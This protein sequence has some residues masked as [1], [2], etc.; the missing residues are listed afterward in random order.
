LA[1]D[2]NRPTKKQY[3]TF[4]FPCGVNYSHWKN[5]LQRWQ[6][7]CIY[8]LEG[9]TSSKGYQKSASVGQGNSEEDFYVAKNSLKDLYPGTSS[10]T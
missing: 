8:A 10:R 1:E 9:Q 2:L 6:N 3:I 7:G 4:D 5:I